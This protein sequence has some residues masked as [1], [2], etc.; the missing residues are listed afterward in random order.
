MNTINWLSPSTASSYRTCGRQ[1]Y[2]RKILGIQNKSNYSTTIYGSCMHKA[3]EVLLNSKIHQSILSCDEYIDVFTGEYNKNIEKATIWT[4]E[5]AENLY[6]IGVEACTSFYNNWFGKFNPIMVESEFL[7]IRGKQKRPIKLIAD[8]LEDGAIWDW[9]FGKTSQPN[10][11]LLN[12]TSYAIA[13]KEKFG[14]IPDVFILAQ[15]YSKKRV[16]GVYIYSFKDFEKIKIPITTEWIDYYLDIYDIVE[17]GIDANIWLPITEDK[18]GL[19]KN[20]GYRLQ[21]ICNVK[22]LYLP[23]I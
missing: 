9:K 7:I 16:D 20:C 15:K 17:R 13:Y 5:T 21:G 14:Y 10:N 22:N 12:M 6:N 23:K 19:C 3:N 18:S 11:Y 2:Y 8:M 4:N 1:V